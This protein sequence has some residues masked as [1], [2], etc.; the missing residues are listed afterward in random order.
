MEK[1]KFFSNFSVLVI[2]LMLGFIGLTLIPRLSV[3][4]LPSKSHASVTVQSS[5]GDASPEVTD[6]ELTGPIERVVARLRGVH[7]INSTSGHGTTTIQVI[8]DK[9]TDPEVFR[10]E[11]ATVL[12]QLYPQLPV[13]ASYP[14]VSLNRPLENNNLRG[15]IIGYTLSGLGTEKRIAEIAEQRIRP[16][17]TQIKGIH[18]ISITGGQSEE[19]AIELDIVRLRQSRIGIADFQAQLQ[20]GFSAQGLGVIFSGDRLL[21]IAIKQSIINI[22][23]LENY[24]IRNQ[25]GQIFYV[26]DVATVKIQETPP[27]SYFRINGKQ[28]IYI[29]VAPQEHI[30]NIELVNRIKETMH[31]VSEQL[32]D[33]GFR[34]AMVYDNTSH[35]KDELGKIYLR[36]SLSLAILLLFVL[37]I[38]RKWRYL[39]IVILSLVI[40]LSLSFILYYIFRIEIHLYSLAGITISLGLI[41]DNVIV[42]VEDIRHTGRNRIFAAILA[43]TL[44]A[45]GA[46]FVIFLLEDSARINLL[47]F[48]IAIIINLLVSLPVAYFFIPA[49]LNYLPVNAVPGKLFFRR[50]RLIVR[51]THVY[52]NQLLFI[53]RFR[54]LFLV[55]FILCFGLP[56]FLMPEEIKGDNWWAKMY[57]NTFG[58]EFYNN[59]IRE[60]VNQ[61]LGGSLY[62][63]TSN[64]SGFLGNPDEGTRAQ[65]QIVI[66]MPNG[67]T[68]NQ[69]DTITRG[70]EDFI[71]QFGEEIGHFT[72]NVSSANNSVITIH[73]EKGSGSEFPQYLKHLL[74]QRAMSSGAADFAVFGI[75]KGFN[76]AIEMD[77]F[78]STI[79]I[80]G[81]NYQQ[82][83]SIG[84]EVRD[85]LMKNSR[86]QN[87]F[88][89]TR[90]RW[91]PGRYEEFIIEMERPE[92]FATY[93]IGKQ[94]VS[95]ALQAIDQRTT[96]VGNLQTG[97][98]GISR[99]GIVTNSDQTIPIWAAM[100]VPLL[101]DNPSVLRLKDLATIEKVRVGDAIVREN[102]E[103]FVNVHYRF[104]GSRKLNQLM[105]NQIVNR[106]EDNLPYG[107]SIDAPDLNERWWGNEG[108]SYIWYILLVLSVIYI[109]CSAL[110]ES[111]I[112][113]LAVILMIPFSFIG[114]LLT[115]HFLSLQF[116]QGGYASLLLLSGLVTNA[117]LYIINDLN[118]IRQIGDNVNRKER[119]LYIK[120]FNA[121]AMPILITT[122]SAILSLLPFMI[123][124]TEKGFWFTLSAGTIGG[125]MFSVLG[126]YFLLPLCLLGSKKYVSDF[127]NKQM[128]IRFWTFTNRKTWERRGHYKF[129]VLKKPTK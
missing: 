60:Y 31:S 110:L 54:W 41:I 109:I 122:S 101:I 28:L 100:N 22:S 83:L 127:P 36:T 23:D 4:L 125:L 119:K 2:S 92:Y 71:S 105:Q 97:T 50:K 21:E 81:Y 13:T 14:I 86:V 12:R 89:T 65:L 94:T 118:Y 43:S 42:I 104:V 93:H 51:F 96:H 35:I 128:K 75:G 61:Y 95:E 56:T 102:Q 121:K 67:S 85:S 49:L 10:F 8:L 84:L 40:N 9:W 45:L 77:N 47:D 114:V 68:L 32:M 39:V 19:V 115:F 44:T 73:F 113:P 107:Y 53:L 76:N 3:Q 59:T 87:V 129:P 74:E 34:L 98:N 6:L 88:V 66:S 64:R 126:A 80:K 20:N 58:S 78:D 117:A 16:A 57:N 91:E 111:L 38:T 79:E 70:F 112:Q 15:N 48:A 27:M 5:M 30:N 55:I 90:N 124:G 24:P 7:K 25:E 108:H 120:A 33:D 37:L 46:L 116:D 26:R 106:I 62:L 103:Y 69:I 29:N 52:E 18:E 1:T 11:A 72:S 63:Y 123:S 17:L 99:V 82:L